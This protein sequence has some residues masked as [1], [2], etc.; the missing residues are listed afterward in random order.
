MILLLDLQ[1]A[2]RLD[3]SKDT[4]VHVST[5]ATYDLNSITPAVSNLWR[6]YEACVFT[7]RR[8]ISD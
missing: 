4:S 8:K 2:M 3:R 6:W 1:G 5:C 7:S